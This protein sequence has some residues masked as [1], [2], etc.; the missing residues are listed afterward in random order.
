MKSRLHFF[1][2]GMSAELPCLLSPEHDSALNGQLKAEFWFA[3][4]FDDSIQMIIYSI[5]ETI[6]NITH[7]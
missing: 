3:R 6:I 7:T 5:L 4:A 1:A 2:F